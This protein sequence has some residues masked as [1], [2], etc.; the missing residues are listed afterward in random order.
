M[1]RPARKLKN[2]EEKLAAKNGRSNG[3]SGAK[4]KRWKKSVA[5]YK[6]IVEAVG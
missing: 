2:L 4:Q 1:N 6:P 3:K 5:V